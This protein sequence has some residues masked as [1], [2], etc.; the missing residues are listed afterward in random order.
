MTIGNF[1]QADIVHYVE[2]DFMTD[3]NINILEELAWNK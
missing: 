3:E 1:K 2:K